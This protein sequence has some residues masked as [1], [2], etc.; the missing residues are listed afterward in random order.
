MPLWAKD[1]KQL[2]YRRENHV[3]VVD[4][5]TDGGFQTSKPRMLFEKP[6]Y[7]NRLSCRTYDL[8]YDGKRFLMVKEEQ[9]KAATITEMILVQNWFEE[10]KQRMPVK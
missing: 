6:G 10:L 2:F 7:Q 8:S 4:V 9:Q 5:R 3:W 1:G